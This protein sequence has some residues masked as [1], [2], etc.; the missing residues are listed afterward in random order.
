[1]AIMPFARNES[2]RFIS[3]TKT[4]EYLA[5]GQPVI[6]TPIHDVVH[7]YGENGLVWIADTA[8]EFIDAADRIMN[9]DYDA[10]MQ[11]LAGAD[12]FIDTMSWDKT[13]DQMDA[14][15]REAIAAKSQ[16]QNL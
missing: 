6:S 16:H 4:P 14:H 9:M 7:P 1:M 15:I 11:W 13:F 3:P 5:G 12:A 8:D 10:Y 2:T